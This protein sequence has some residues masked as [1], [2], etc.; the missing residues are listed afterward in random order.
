MGEPRKK[1]GGKT[2][3]LEATGLSGI[4]DALPGSGDY[5]SAVVGDAI[6]GNL[7]DGLATHLALKTNNTFLQSLLYSGSSYLMLELAQ[8]FFDGLGGFTAGN[9]LGFSIAQLKVENLI[10]GSK[11]GE[12][13]CCALED[14]PSVGLCLVFSDSS[15]S[16]LYFWFIK[17]Y[18]IINGHKGIFVSLIIGDGEGRVGQAGCHT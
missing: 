18:H 9:T 17:I 8:V 15:A 1:H 2:A 10:L 14:E 6:S 13:L 4:A 3:V 7:A 12:E 11:P 16:L 5:G